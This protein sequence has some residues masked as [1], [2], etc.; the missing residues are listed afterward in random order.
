MEHAY[1]VLKPKYKVAFRRIRLTVINF[2]VSLKN[3]ITITVQ[4]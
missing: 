3:I 4:R 2:I 1:Q